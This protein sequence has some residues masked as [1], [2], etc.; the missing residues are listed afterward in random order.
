M[1]LFS[2]ILWHLLM[3][4]AELFLHRMNPFSNGVHKPP[5]IPRF[6]KGRNSVANPY[7]S[8]NKSRIRKRSTR[9]RVHKSI[10]LKESFGYIS[11]KN[12]LK[13]C[14]LNV[15]GLTDS[16]F[17]DVKNVL[18]TKAP[19]ICV[20]LE[21]K[22]RLEDD[23]VSLEVPGYDVSEH[24]RSDIAGDKGGGG[25]AIFTRKADGLVFHDYDP[26]LP[27]PS[28]AFV[29]NE[30]A[31]KT[32]E[33]AHSK[34]AVCAVYAGFQAPDDRNAAWNDTL[35][36]VLRDEAADLRKKG[37]RVVLLGDFNGHVGDRAD[38][39][40]T[41]NKH[42]INRNGQRFI[43]FLHDCNCV[44]INGYQNLTTGLWTRQRAGVSTILDY[45]VI[46]QEH[47]S[48]VMS[49][50]IDEQGLYGGGSDHNWIFLDLSDNL[51]KKQRQYN[52]P[53]PKTSWNISHDQNWE[54]F[55]ATLDD[56]VD[57]TDISLDAAALA[58]KAAEMLLHAGAK[59]VGFRRPKAKTSML[60]TSLPRFLV[61]ELQLKRQ[62][63]RHWKSRCSWFSSLPAPQRTE[64][65][66]DSLSAAE[67]AFQEQ[68]SK[69]ESSFLGL[70]NSSRLKVLKK[71]SENSQ[72]AK[73]F[74]WSYVNKK[75]LKS[76]TI[77][78]VTSA[79]G[80]VHC[81][82]EGIVKQVEQH[83]VNTFN[84]SLDPIPVTA[85]TDDHSYATKSRPVFTTSD[86]SADHP[87]SCSAS[88]TLP[89]SDGSGS[90]KTDPDGWINKEFTLNEVVQGI[91][92]LKGGKAVGVDNIP[93]EFLINAGVKFWELLTLLYNKIKRS[94]TFPPGWNK[95]RVALI[96][97]KGAKELLGNYRP[98]T[99]I[100]SMSGLYSR[101]LNERLTCV[102]EEHGLLGE[103]QNGFRK[104]RSGSDNS[105]VLD[106]IFWKQKALRKKVHVAFIDIAKAYDTVDRDVLW[107]KLEGFGFGGDF[108]SSL[109][110]IYSGD[111]V[112][113]VVN[114][115]STR[116]VYLRRGLRQGCSLSPILFALYIADMGQAINLSSEGFRIGNTVVSGLF[117]A[118]DLALVARD[119]EGLLRLLSLTKKHADLL[120]MRINTDRNKSEVISPDGA[121]GD[122]WQ[123]MEDNGGTVLSLRQVLKYKYLG[124]PVLGSM[125]KIGVT[126]QKECIQKAHKYKASCFFMSR[127]G[128]DVVDMVLATWCN[129]AIPSILFGTEMI[130][131]TESTILEL[132][133]TQNQVAKYA[134]GLPINSPGICAQIELGLKPF[135]QLLYEHQ[136]KFYSRVLQLD[137]CRWVKQALLDHQSFTWSSPYIS[138][139]QGIRSRLKMFGMPMKNYRLHRFTNSYF[140]DSTNKALAAL[141]LPWLSPIK[142]FRRKIYVQESKSST[143]LAQF[144]YNV[145]PIGN[146]YPRV[147]SLS[148]QRYCPLCPNSTANTVSHLAMFCPYVELVRKEQ[149]S[150]SSFRNTCILKGFSEDYSF[151][152]Y[153][154]GYDWNENPVLAG[155]FLERGE[156]L[157]TL[158]ES[159][160]SRW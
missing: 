34:T 153:I 55:K 83:L 46:A 21:T 32:L 159:W 12:K 91:K 84:G 116:P 129:I 122:L 140:V 101:L 72:E 4:I 114:G 69:V 131:F 130:P 36:S 100:V 71:C 149:T 143:T 81:S 23:G 42:D 33:S 78:A 147:G 75:N 154:N 3:Y 133:R 26:D 43:D 137:D 93:N 37:F 117:F 120:R 53:K 111:S 87:Y 18:A 113:A 40:I 74:F 80:V 151:W 156:E 110:S 14:F 98:L 7:T 123:V 105:F 70:R 39:G 51:V 48:S 152:L 27:D 150:I 61:T 8:Y 82:P 15:D 19:D 47:L 11:K 160:L 89:S 56:L 30:R 76:D 45:A 67:T 121:E 148:V 6:R 88:P 38:V 126:K 134:L 135:R 57:N 5:L 35:Y 85:N 62:L 99:V 29:R 73:R 109:K 92:K 60:A 136:L 118:D 95:G 155:S 96:H 107:R 125:H 49:M 124:N 50:F 128:P 132:E 54:P 20:L 31:W 10:K 94:G 108:L 139:I 112:Q 103:I 59:N 41:G 9:N 97:K 77:D 127:E 44:H 102:V 90:V 13:C 2:D 146:K 115:V 17:A 68:K 66:K 142:A 86:S 16:S 58:S 52:A 63:E 157:N 144:R 141:S 22:R 138:H 28:Q 25:L 64:A 65:L 104:G 1:L 158:M 145:A 106:T 79:D 119:A 24:N